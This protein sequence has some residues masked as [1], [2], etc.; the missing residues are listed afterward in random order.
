MKTCTKCG[1][2]KDLKEY[3]N[4]KRGKF[5]V[6]SRCKLCRGDYLK[7]YKEI[8]KY[9]YIY[10]ENNKPILIN[11][12]KEYIKRN[13]ESYNFYQK[14]YQKSNGYKSQK[15]YNEKNKDALLKKGYKRRN[16][17]VKNDIPYKLRLRISTNICNQLKKFLLNK[18]DNT[19]NYLGCT[20]DYYKQYIEQQFYPEMNWDNWGII[21]EIDHIDPISN[22]N[23]INEE[24]I[25]KA[26]IYKNTKPL[27]KTTEIANELGY[28]NEIGNRNKSNN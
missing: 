2:S 25:Y 19:L 18:K 8:N 14:L 3:Q 17:R 28:I 20:F 11:K 10:Y 23:L 4:D 7:K 24:E 22:F 5:G 27:F 26:F 9:D 16:E 15:L 13:K 21:W 6:E 1:I 12:Q